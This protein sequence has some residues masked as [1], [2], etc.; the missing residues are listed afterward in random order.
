MDLNFRQEDVQAGRISVIVWTG[1]VPVSFV[2]VG[3]CGASPGDVSRVGEGQISRLR[4][5]CRI[6]SQ[7]DIA[8]IFQLVISPNDCSVAGIIGRSVGL[9]RR[10]V[11]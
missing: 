7:S 11:G 6:I 9:W 5:N 10:T 3:A 2:G 4:I 8:G 1:A